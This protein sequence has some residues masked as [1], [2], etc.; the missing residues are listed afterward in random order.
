MKS[1][2][3]GIRSILGMVFVEMGMLAFLFIFVFWIPNSLPKQ[4]EDLALLDGVYQNTYTTSPILYGPFEGFNE[5]I[6]SIGFDYVVSID[7]MGFTQTD[8]CVSVGDVVSTETVIA[9]NIYG[10]LV[11]NNIGFVVGINDEAGLQV[12]IVPYDSIY[13]NWEMTLFEYVAFDSERNISFSIGNEIFYR[14]LAVLSLDTEGLSYRV[15]VKDLPTVGIY[16]EGEKILVYQS[17]LKASTM[18]VR[19]TFIASPVVDG[20]AIIHILDPTKKTNNVLVLTVAIGEHNSVFTEIISSE[21]Q[22]YYRIIKP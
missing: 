17:S 1:H 16:F 6:G 15:I 5:Y 22:L 11:A 8:L 4:N 2:P 10:S 18:F 3:L 7:L 13:L 21:L 12:Q 9:T 14:D 20:T 19:S